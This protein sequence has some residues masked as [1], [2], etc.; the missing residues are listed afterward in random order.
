M[1]LWKLLML[2][3]AM[4]HANV[5]LS[6]CCRD[7]HVNSLMLVD[8]PIQMALRCGPSITLFLMTI[9]H[10]NHFPLEVDFL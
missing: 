1:Y 5:S 3:V 10:G 4:Y 9:V 7:C 8:M 2:F 6:I